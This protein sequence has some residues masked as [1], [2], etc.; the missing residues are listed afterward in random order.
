MAIDLYGI[1]GSPP[2]RAVMLLMT[3]LNLTPNFKM[4]D[5]LAGDQ[6]KPEFTQLSPQ[7]TVPT[8]VDNGFTLTESRAIMKY[9]VE[10]YGKDSG[11]I[12]ENIEE[13]AVMNQMLDFELGTVSQRMR[14]RYMYPLK[15][16]LPAPEYTGPNL[17]NAMLTLD[18]FL[19]GQDWVAGNKMTVADFSYASSIATM[20]AAGYD[21][22]PYKNIQNWY[23][24]AKSTMKGWDYNEGGAAKI[25]AILK[26]AQSG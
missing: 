8:I 9:L 21:I 23:N 10:K 7:H 24:K 16:K 11:L 4:V 18:L 15:F 26:S 20:I 17:D 5:I 1:D 25:G 3:A 2:V 22:S 12:P 13:R 19:E 14:E 6:L